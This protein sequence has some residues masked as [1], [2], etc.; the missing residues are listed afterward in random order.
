MFLPY[1]S[2][3]DEFDTCITNLCSMSHS[4]S[5]A[6]VWSTIGSLW[7]CVLFRRPLCLCNLCWQVLQK[8]ELWSW[9]KLE[10]TGEEGWWGEIY[11][12]VSF[13]FFLLFIRAYSR[14]KINMPEL[15]FFYSFGRWVRRDDFVP[16]IC[17]VDLQLF[18]ISYD[19]WR[20]PNADE[21]NY[22]VFPVV[23]FILC[24]WTVCVHDVVYY[25]PYFVQLD[26]Y[27]G[28]RFFF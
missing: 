13:C 24:C 16:A 21:K 15:Y 6:F 20:F 8:D 22:V 27:Q 10:K 25:I 3:R 1:S 23:G 17:R 4:K 2:S 9:G 12:G 19:S 18:H 11:E 5:D 7:F 28:S 14:L 26:P